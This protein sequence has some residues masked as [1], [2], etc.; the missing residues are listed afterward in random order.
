MCPACTILIGGLTAGDGFL[1]LGLAQAKR[2]R[3]RFVDLCRCRTVRVGG[4]KAQDR[5]DEL[6]V[7][8]DGHGLCILQKC[9]LNLRPKP[10]CRVWPWGRRRVG[11]GC[12]PAARWRV[13][14]SGLAEP[15]RHGKL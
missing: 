15:V 5:L 11:L 14:R 4:E 9:M 6:V 10:F 13:R 7:G 3:R 12:A 8:G 2:E 1:S